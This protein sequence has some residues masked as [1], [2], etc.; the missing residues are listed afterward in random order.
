MVFVYTD[1]DI[2]LINLVYGRYDCAVFNVNC[3]IWTEKIVLQ[4]DNF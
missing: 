4:L 2:T 1:V 3:F